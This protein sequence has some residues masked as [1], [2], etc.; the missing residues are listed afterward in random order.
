MEYFGLSKPKVLAKGR[1]QDLAL[2]EYS[3]LYKT[4]IDCEIRPTLRGVKI[5]IKNEMIQG[6]EERYIHSI[7]LR[8]K[9][10][11]KAIL[12]CTNEEASINCIT[13]CKLVN[14][15]FI[16]QKLKRIECLYRLSRIQWIPE[17]IKYANDNNEHIRI[18]RNEQKDR[19]NGKG[20]W[21]QKLRYHNGLADFIIIFN[22]LY[23]K[24]D[25]KKLNYLDFRTAYPIFL[26]QERVDLD[27]EYIKCS[28]NKNTGFP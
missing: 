8:D 2:A 19:T 17:I 21:K 6:M 9:Q 7:S 20:V 3:V 25:K 22:E 11:Y 10:Y 13:K 26:P 15:T 12:P 28:K 24:T 23:D 27:K 4:F 1:I 14:S 16:F 18:W 5:F